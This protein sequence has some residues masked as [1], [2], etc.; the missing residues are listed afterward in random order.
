MLFPL[1]TVWLFSLLWILMSISFLF[2]L[3][4]DSFGRCLWLQFYNVVHVSSLSSFHILSSN[5]SLTLSSLWNQKKGSQNSA[6]ADYHRH[7]LKRIIN[8][9]CVKKLKH[10]QPGSPKKEDEALKSKTTC[11]CFWCWKRTCLDQATWK[12]EVAGRYLGDI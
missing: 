8:E 12:S 1:R 7:Y 6:M 2:F 4:V 3:Y 10:M 5:L 9:A 11:W